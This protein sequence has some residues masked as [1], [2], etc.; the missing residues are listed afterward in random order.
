VAAAAEIRVVSTE[1]ELAEDAA[2]RTIAT[3][4][5]AQHERGSASLVLTGGGILEKVMETIG[6]SSARDAVEWNRVDVFWGD[7]RYVPVESAD[8]NELPARRLMLDQLAVDPARIH[9]MAASDAGYPNAEAAATAYAEMLEAVA[10]RDQGGHVPHFDVILL[11]IGPDGHCC[12]L[13][14]EQPGVYETDSYVIAVHNSPKPPPD[15]LS[16]TFRALAQAEQIWFIASG[17]AKANAVALALS[18][19]GSVQVPAAGPHGRSRTLWLLDA[20]AASRLPASLH[21][22]AIS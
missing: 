9:P 6:A 15:R 8:R 18:G 2:A 12:S 3:L 14:P 21:P 16:L 5:H 13:F 19:A 7:E 17:E 20:A 11:G 22:P 1:Q 4:A 10:R